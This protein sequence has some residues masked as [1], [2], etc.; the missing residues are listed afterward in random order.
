[1]NSLFSVAEIIAATGGRAE[2]VDATAV[3]SISIDSRE[4]EPGALFVAIAGDRFDGHDFVARAIANGAA[5]AM[6]SEARAAELGGQPLIIVLEALGGLVGLARAARTRST[7]RIVAVTGSVG[8]T[9][10]KQMI[11]AVLEKSGKTHASI[12]SFNNH[13]GVP[14]TL[15]RMPDDVA[16]GVFEIGMSAA[17]EITPLVQMVEPDIAVIT[18]IAPAHLESLGSLEAIAEAK[19]EIFAGM[20][21]DS[22]AIVN[23]DHDYLDV[24]RRAATTA[25]VGRFISY[26]FADN[27]DV[28]IV[29]AVSSSEGMGAR[30]IWA[31]TELHIEIAA[32]GRH[33]LANATAAL[34]VARVLGLDLEN[35]SA[36]LAPLSAPEGRG[37]RFELGLADKPLTVIDESFNANPASMMAALAVFTEVT[38]PLG[39]KVLVMGDMLELGEAGADLHVQLAQSVANCGAESIFLVGENM[40]ILGDALGPDVVSEHGIDVNHI[41]QTIL[42]GL[43]YGDVVMIKG[44]KGVGLGSLILKIRNRFNGAQ[45]LKT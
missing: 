26:G 29:D 35:A 40:K 27:A 38:A 41:A 45:A 39:R 21:A 37:S 22:T 31:D 30:V 5:V 10:T 24:L 23:A 17:G 3:F 8:K 7:A 16:F 13:W 34:C 33:Q 28:R 6:V 4:I 14:L 20:G 1:M 12:R 9:T 42:N 11:G 36:A 18:S 32:A 25:G 43:D 15:A 44:S 19:A 2:G